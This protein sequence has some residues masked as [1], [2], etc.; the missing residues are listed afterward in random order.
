MNT[1][2]H[3]QDED[4]LSTGY[5]HLVMQTDIK[6]MACKGKRKAVPMLN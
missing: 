3:L 5:I 2:H 6:F 4:I 1:V